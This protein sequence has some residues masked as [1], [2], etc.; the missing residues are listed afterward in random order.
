MMDEGIMYDSGKVWITD[1][2]HDSWLMT[3]D[4]WWWQMMG[5]EWWIGISPLSWLVA[6]VVVVRVKPLL[7]LVLLMD[8]GLPWLKHDTLCQSM[9][10][11]TS[12][13][14][15]DDR[16]VDHG[17]CQ[18]SRPSMVPAPWRGWGGPWGLTSAQCSISS[19]WFFCW[20]EFVDS[21]DGFLF[22][23]LGYTSIHW[24]P[25]LIECWG[26]TTIFRGHTSSPSC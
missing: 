22:L 12:E 13:L 8:E 19:S 6:W 11:C 24:C 4:Q 17:F 10:S 2:K 23:C 25:W 18:V 14:F 1:D 15:V 16:F 3:K 7:K 26:S 21:R 5:D 9:T 20:R